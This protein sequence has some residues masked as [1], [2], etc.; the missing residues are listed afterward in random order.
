MLTVLEVNRRLT[1][2]GIQLL[3]DFKGTS[4]KHSFKCLAC[5]YVWSSLSPFLWKRKHGCPQCAKSNNGSTTRLSHE[6]VSA[7]LMQ[8][9]IVILDQYRG[10]RYQN[11]FQCSNRHT[12]RVTAGVPLKGYGCPF[13]LKWTEE[14]II[15]ELK[16]RNFKLLSLY[17]GSIDNKHRIECNQS[18]Q[19]TTKISTIL[20]IGS[21]CPQCWRIDLVRV[22]KELKAKSICPI[23]KLVNSYTK[24]KFKCL[25]CDFQWYTSVSHIL[26]DN[27][28]CPRC[29]QCAKLTIS[30]V[31]KRLRQRKIHL[32]GDFK[33]AKDR[34]QLQCQRC[35]TKWNSFLTT[36]CPSCHSV[37]SVQEKEVRNILELIFPGYKFPK[38]RPLFL[39]GNREHPLELD[40]YNEKLKIAVEVQGQQ[41]YRYTKHFHRNQEGFRRLHLRDERKRFLCKYHGIKLVRVPYWKKNV[42]KY[43]RTKLI[44]Q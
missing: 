42:E 8:R 44:D 12:W 5:S 28:G 11:S 22:R 38:V 24:T 1:T 40:C 3:E 15:T 7:R 23:D 32:I 10:S 37:E 18:H 9:G 31:K 20:R 41:H 25:V 2:R 21:G 35:E 4:V 27:T 16:K 33:T 17:S 34:H 43:L 14:K 39:K 6:E 30:E 36:N 29:R 26:N 13:C 19:W